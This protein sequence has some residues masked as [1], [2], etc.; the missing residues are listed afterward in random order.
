MNKITLARLYPGQTVALAN[1]AETATVV[2][3][4]GANL[5]TIT[6]KGR[7]IAGVQRNQLSVWVRDRWMGGAH[8]EIK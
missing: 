5:Y 3:R 6:W 1:C 2:K 4:D 7:E 8:N